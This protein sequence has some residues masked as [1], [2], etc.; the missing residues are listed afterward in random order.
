MTI[1]GGS[2]A[3]WNVGLSAG[4]GSM[5][6]A[7]VVTGAAY[8]VLTAVLGEMTSAMPFAGTRRGGCPVP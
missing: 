3:S 8:V 5:F 7:I 1:V 4:Y 2:D 6:V